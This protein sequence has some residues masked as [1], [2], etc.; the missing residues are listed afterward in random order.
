MSP[1]GTLSAISWQPSLESGNGPQ[2]ATRSSASKTSQILHAAFGNN[3]LARRDFRVDLFTAFTELCVIVKLLAVRGNDWFSAAGMLLVL[4]WLA[5][6]TLLIVLHAR[7]MDESDMKDTVRTAARL[8]KDLSQREWWWTTLF[9]ALHLPF[10][11]YP[12]YLAAF[13]PWIPPDA[14]GF[15]WFLRGCAWFLDLCLATMVAKFSFWA[16]LW[17]IFIGWCGFK[18][19][20]R[21]WK[22]VLLLALPIALAWLLLASVS[23]TQQ[24]C[25]PQKSKYCVGG[26]FKG[27]FTMDTVMHRIVDRAMNHC[28]KRCGCCCFWCLL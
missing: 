26:D 21:L 24:I 11:G 20:R 8:E 9:L 6:Q 17:A 27:F 22:T 4:G 2:A 12:C 1:G 7:E 3:A 28:I 18:R 19:R 15:L 5:V 23:H 13:H 10:F 16:V 14:K 25:G